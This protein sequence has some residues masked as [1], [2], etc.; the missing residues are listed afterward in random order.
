MGLPP[1]DI[2]PALL[3]FNVGVELG[4]LA[5]MLTVVGVMESLKRLGSEKYPRWLGWVPTYSI[6]TM[7]SFWCIQRIAAFWG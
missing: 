7:A 1:Q 3:F 4:Q 6:G 5:F 2:P